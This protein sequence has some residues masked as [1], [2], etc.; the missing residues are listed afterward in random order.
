MLSRILGFLNSL[1]LLS[2]FIILSRYARFA[3]VRAT[4]GL[5]TAVALKSTHYRSTPVTLRRAVVPHKV[6]AT[7][8]AKI[9][10]VVLVALRITGLGSAAGRRSLVQG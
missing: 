6:I 7:S 3:A 8:A 10:N 9:Q 5:C 1:P 4:D 2:T